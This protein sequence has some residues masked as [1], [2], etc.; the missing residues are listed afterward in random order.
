MLM[1]VL[2]TTPMLLFVA[3]GNGLWRK[4]RGWKVVRR[5]ETHR[6]L[7]E[8]AQVRAMECPELNRREKR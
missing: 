8:N 3:D 5:K 4:D 2:F 6:V 7:L 1:G